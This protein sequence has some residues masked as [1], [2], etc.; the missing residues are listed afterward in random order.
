MRV[1]GGGLMQARYLRIE[2]A[3]TPRADP[4][5]WSEPRTEQHVW[6]M[7]AVAAASLALGSSI[8]PGPRNSMM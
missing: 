1:K 7:M 2:A 6:A 5:V 8:Q 4:T 3:E